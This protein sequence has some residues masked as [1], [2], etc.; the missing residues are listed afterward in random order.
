MKVHTIFS[1]FSFEKPVFYFKFWK[2]SACCLCSGKVGDLQT[3]R[4]RGGRELG[5]DQISFIIFFII[6]HIKIKTTEISIYLALNW[7]ISLTVFAASLTYYVATGSY[8][9]LASAPSASPP[10]RG[11]QA[12]LQLLQ[13]DQECGRTAGGS[14]DCTWDCET[15]P[16]AYFPD[17]VGPI[18]FFQ[19][20]MYSDP[21][22][23]QDC[24]RPTCLRFLMGDHRRQQGVCPCRDT[25]TH[26]CS[27]TPP[28]PVSPSGSLCQYDDNGDLIQGL[29]SEDTENNLLEDLCISDVWSMPVKLRESIRYLIKRMCRKEVYAKFRPE[30]SGSSIRLNP[31]EM[32]EFDQTANGNWITAVAIW[33]W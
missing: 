22:C 19:S 7:K 5:G 2:T 13:D 20:Y 28:W 24:V 8:E 9:P 10:E 16:E 27:H 32:V 12:D 30:I 4:Q 6:F 17:F 29:C 3:E 1:F 21:A 15:H 26:F 31:I 33:I 18:A 14:P 11:R 23:L 25:R